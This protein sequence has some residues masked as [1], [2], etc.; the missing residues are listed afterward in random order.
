MIGWQFLCYAT[1]GVALN[2]ALYGV[3]L[4]LTRTLL[5][6]LGAMTVVYATGVLLGFALNRKITFHHHGA[7]RVALLRY[8]VCYVIGYFIDLSL[9]WLLAGQLGMPHEIVQG[10]ITIGL[11]VL[12]FGLQK[13][14]VFPSLRQVDPALFPR[15]AA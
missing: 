3:Y 14:W 4:L 9:L 12:L 2:A 6:S 13:Y 8:V 15:T 7:A 5:D 11:A 1:I 10:G